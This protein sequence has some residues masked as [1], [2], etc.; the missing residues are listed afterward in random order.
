MRNAPEV[1]REVGVDDF[2]VDAF[3]LARI[4][5]YLIARRDAYP[6]VQSLGGGGRDSDDGAH[7]LDDC[8]SRYGFPVAVGRV[9]DPIL[10]A[11]SD[12]VGP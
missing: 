5:D 6:A 10:L 1:V 4:A 7:D 8:R 11:R 9:P 3:P 12:V 2:R